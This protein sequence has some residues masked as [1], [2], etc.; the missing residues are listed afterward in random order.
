MARGRSISSEQLRL[1][2]TAGRGAMRLNSD[3][4]VRGRLKRI[5]RAVRFVT[6]LR[7]FAVALARKVGLYRPFVPGPPKSNYRVEVGDV[8]T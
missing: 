2:R 8:Q 7:R 3:S 5:N 1:R 6:G 4:A